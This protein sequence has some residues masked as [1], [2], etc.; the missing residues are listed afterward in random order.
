MSNY[1]LCDDFSRCDVDDRDKYNWTPLMG[2]VHQGTLETVRALIARGADVNAIG[3]LSTRDEC[4]PLRIAV[5]DDNIPMADLLIKSGAKVNACDFYG[6]TPLIDA[7]WHCNSAMLQL[8]IDA[9]ATMERATK[10]DVLD[11][12]ECVKEG[13]AESNADPAPA[14]KVLA[15]H[16]MLSSAQCGDFDG[17]EEAIANGGD[18]N[19]RD[20]NGR[21]PLFY[22]L[23]FLEPAAIETLIRSKGA[24]PSV[25]DRHGMTL[26]HY[27]LGLCQGDDKEMTRIVSILLKA[28][29]DVNARDIYGRTAV[30]AANTVAI[31]KSLVEAGADLNAR[32]LDGATPL[33]EAQSGALVRFFAEHGADPEARDEDQNTPLSQAVSNFPEDTSAVQALLRAGADVNARLWDGLTVLHLARS[34]RMVRFLITSGADPAAKDMQ[35]RLPTETCAEWMQPEEIEAAF[36]I[37]QSFANIS[38]DK[39]Q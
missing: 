13:A 16:W 15:A 4:T 24:D 1:A 31:A 27:L 26:L 11:A 5:L 12:F 19:E 23:E 36:G 14:L 30:F 35:G 2:A 18:I 39:L 7:C 28:G 33:I 17:V 22:A 21:T 25:R 3:G 32:A 6:N 9:G 29:I 8:L 20:E 37:F 38:T 34:P 10:G